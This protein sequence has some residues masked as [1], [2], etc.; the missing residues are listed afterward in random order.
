VTWLATLARWLDSAGIH[1]RRAIGRRV[2]RRGNQVTLQ[3]LTFSVDNPLISVRE[4]AL[5][6]MGI[7][8]APEIRLARRHLD[9]RLPLIEL[10]GGIGVLSCMINR[11]LIRPRD[12]IVVEANPELIP[13][14]ELN[15]QRNRCQF[16]VMNVALAY[17]GPEIELGIDSLAASRVGAPG[18]RRVRV[19]ATTLESVVR[20]TGFARFNLM[21]DIEGAEVA[22]VEREGGLLGRRVQVLILETHPRF[23]GA[24][25]TAAMLDRIRSLG[26]TELARARTVH[27]FENRS[28]GPP[29][30]A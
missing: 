29:P 7:H 1:A 17:D 3:G 5:I 30:P 14:L 13:T 26:F 19:P 18:Q 8:E 21:V 15:R 25:R 6:Y 27:A 28:G 11:N 20:E 24:A 22:L 16:R 23:T 10:G 4:K 12:H 9:A 2:E